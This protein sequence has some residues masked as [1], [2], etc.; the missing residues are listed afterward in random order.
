MPGLGTTEATSGFGG[1][2]G[3]LLLMADGGGGNEYQ[4]Q[5]ARN[6][7]IW[8]D[9]IPPDDPKPPED[10]KHRFHRLYKRNHPHWYQ[11]P[12]LENPI[13]GLYRNFKVTWGTIF[14]DDGDD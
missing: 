8:K 2:F 1:P 9:T 7:K 12:G 3:A 10:W 13:M 4:E 6:K 11:V 5:A 14:G